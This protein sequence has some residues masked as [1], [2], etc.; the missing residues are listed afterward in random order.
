MIT[1][2]NDRNAFF[3][4]YFYSGYTILYAYTIFSFVL[5]IVVVVTDEDKRSYAKKI[6]E[7]HCIA[8]VPFIVL[9]SL[10][11]EIM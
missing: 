1:L 5:K 10:A 3:F 8:K 11:E 2:K 4:H 6:R 7:K 9:A